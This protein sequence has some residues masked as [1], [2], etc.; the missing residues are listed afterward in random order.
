MF[1]CLARQLSRKRWSKRWKSQFN[2]AMSEERNIENL[3]TPLDEKFHKVFHRF[4]E[5]KKKRLEMKRIRPELLEKKIEHEKK[6]EKFC[7][8]RFLPC[9]ICGEKDRENRETHKDLCDFCLTVAIDDFL[10]INAST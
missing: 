5:G 4:S 9:L 2:S 6:M 3:Q 7:S 8:G 1:G 10:D